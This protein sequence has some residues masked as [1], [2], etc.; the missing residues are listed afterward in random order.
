MLPFYLLTQ[1]KHKRSRYGQ[2]TTGADCP[3]VREI[4]PMTAGAQQPI[5]A[6]AVG[7]S[8]VK[9][10]SIL[11]NGRRCK[12]AAALPGPHP[13]SDFYQSK[14]QYGRHTDINTYIINN[15]TIKGNYQPNLLA[16]LFTNHK[17]FTYDN[18]R[19]IKRRP[20]MTIFLPVQPVQLC[21]LPV[22]RTGLWMSLCA[23]RRPRPPI[24]KMPTFEQN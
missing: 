13:G 11:E 18:I 7:D 12:N 10:P 16:F 8:A 20:N 3:D 1:I 4:N 17:S 2:R 22:Q 5:S 24:I 19:T 9:P 21:I 6:I 15:I 23:L 14:P